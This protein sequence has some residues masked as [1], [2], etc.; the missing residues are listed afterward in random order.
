MNTF[1]NISPEKGAPQKRHSEKSPK[2]FTRRTLLR[3]A[4]ILAAGTLAKQI[5]ISDNKK[6][7]FPT[8]EELARLDEKL[9]KIAQENKPTQRQQ[10]IERSDIDSIGKT[11]TEQLE[12]GNTITLNKDT[13]SA[14]YTHWRY[15]YRTDSINYKDGIVAGLERM[16]PW[17]TEIKETFTDHGVPQ[18]YMYLAIAESHFDMQATSHKAAVGPYQIIEDTAHDYNLRIEDNYDE[19]RDPIKSAQLCARYLKKKFEQFGGNDMSDNEDAWRL[20]LLSYNGGF[21]GKYDKHIIEQDS[22]AE[23]ALRNDEH[24][25]QKGDSLYTIAQAYNT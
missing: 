22:K 8:D 17:I 16:Q 2:K 14:I 20:A 6:D 4:T 19:R 9:E 1:E 15:E 3:A 21:V 11:F 23:I 13:R 25:V 7:N 12:A 18:E 24:V 5:P 10:N